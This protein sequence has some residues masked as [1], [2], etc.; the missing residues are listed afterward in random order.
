MPTSELLAKAAA[1]DLRAQD[2]L[3]DAWLPVVLRW[4]IRLG[5]PRVAHED[6]AHDVFIVVLRKLDTLERADRFPAWL[7]GI[8]R[9]VLRKHRGRAWVLR[10]AGSE[11]HEVA[12]PH[13]DPEGDYRRSETTR[14]VQV[15]LS[16]LP[17]R[18]R[19]VLV[20]CDLEERTAPEVAEL[21]GIPLGTVASRLRLAREKFEKLAREQELDA[22]FAPAGGVS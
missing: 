20:L 3:F 13:Q 4:C 12:D 22:A 11:V 8:T 15:L 14:R 7:F 16:S 19:E 18:Q 1:G 2:E 21:L 6:A 9:R 17:E 10:W 5:G